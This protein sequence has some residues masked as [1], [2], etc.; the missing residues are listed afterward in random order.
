MREK[1][2]DS[3]HLVAI[4]ICCLCVALFSVFDV[5]WVTLSGLIG[6]MHMSNIEGM[7]HSFK[8]PDHIPNIPYISYSRDLNMTATGVKDSRNARGWD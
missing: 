8:P 6:A 2:R 4:D 3:L 7:M 1:W 5:D